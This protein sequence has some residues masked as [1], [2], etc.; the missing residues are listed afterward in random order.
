MIGDDDDNNRIS[1][2]DVDSGSD[3]A[4]DQQQSG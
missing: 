4:D 1:K 2:Y 3:D